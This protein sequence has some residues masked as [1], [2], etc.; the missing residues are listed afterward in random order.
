[1]NSHT[2]LLVNNLMK[3]SYRFHNP[4]DRAENTQGLCDR[5]AAPLM[6][7]DAQHLDDAELTAYH[8]NWSPFYAF[9]NSNEF[10]AESTPHAGS[11]IGLSAPPPASASTGT[12]SQLAQYLISGYWAWANYQGTSPRQWA[13]TTITYNI[14]SLT[15]GEQVLALIALSDWAT[16]APLNFVRTHGSANITYNHNGSQSAAT[17]QTVSG[18]N[19]TSAVVDISSDWWPN[20]DIN[21]YMMQTYLHET[22][23]ALGLGHQGPYNISAHYG[24]DNIFTNDTWQWSVM[25][26][27]DQSNYGGAT[28]DYVVGPEMVDISA[29][30]SMYGA[31]TRPGNTTYGFNSNAGTPYDFTQYSGTPAFTI[32]NT[33][34]N[35][36]LDVSGYAT[37]DTIDVR[38]GH[39]SSI[40]GY[41]NNIG[42]YLTTNIANIVA[43]S[44]NDLII[45]NPDLVGTL[46][47][48]SGFDTFQS[49]QFG[50]YLYTLA[51]LHTGDIINFT[52]A[53]LNTFGFTEVG[54]T[55]SYGSYTLN[56]SNTPRGHFIETSNAT[57][58]VNLTRLNL[59]QNDFN[60]DARS[61]IAWRNDNGSLVSWR[62]NG[63]QVVSGLSL[64]YQGNIVAPNTSWTV[65]GTGDF[66]GDRNA[67]LLWRNSNGSLSDWTM[68]GA[69]ILSSQ[70]LTYQGGVVTP[71]SLWTVAGLGDFNDDGRSDVL[72]RNSNGSL[73]EWAMNGSTI[74]ASQTITYQ[75]N[76]VAP[77]HSWSV[78][79]IGD[80]NGGPNSDLLWRS[81]SGALV[82]WAM[83]GS[84]VVSSQSVTFQNTVAQ[85]DSS[86]SLAGIGDFNGDGTED[87][88]WRSTN[89]SLVDWAMNGSTIASSQG[90]T[91]QGTAVA[92]DASW[93]IAEVGDFNGDGRQDILWRGSNGALMDWAMNGSQ[94][95]S[96]QNITSQGS[97]V[98][99]DGSWHAQARPTDFV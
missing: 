56:L 66:N 58:G 61:D 44:G 54:T 37:N 10:V 35:N 23:H 6:Q 76:A 1:M 3:D 91:Y 52:D 29:I 50:L 25:S 5:D 72:W 62:M 47:G 42:V 74:T 78:V 34:S 84:Q 26:Y 40:G 92:P 17:S 64:T 93:N 77:D 55:L 69:T 11:A 80:F 31:A 71:N 13:S 28:Y 79:G 19:L 33:S 88:L 75:G 67:D 9:D 46:T 51:N 36:T 14:D 94:I 99:P 27:F 57:A 70:A 49:T 97:L 96:S 2:S 43:G 22:G 39:W 20:T 82:D 68:S 45:P 87:I 81:S 48:G 89:G 60:N 41:V 53:D 16:V 83:N 59:D 73:V 32:Y 90:L 12:I 98:N 24:A 18:T 21:S 85:P 65:A 95:T 15:I 63:A 86:W 7:S 38:P 30:Q 8:R 4:L